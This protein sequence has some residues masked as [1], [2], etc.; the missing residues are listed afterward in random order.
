MTEVDGGV[1]K[2]P[3]ESRSRAPRV[4]G[5]LVFKTWEVCFQD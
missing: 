4:R 5:S 3:L 2:E 1:K